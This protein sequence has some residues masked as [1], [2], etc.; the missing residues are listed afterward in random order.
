MKEISS[1]ILLGM[2]LLLV[3]LIGAIPWIRSLVSCHT[4]KILEDNKVNIFSR[5]KDLSYKESS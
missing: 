2:S 3:Y 5:K 1:L 4:Q